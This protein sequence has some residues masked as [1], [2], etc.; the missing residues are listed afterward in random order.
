MLNPSCF[1][2]GR[3]SIAGS[4]WE[5]ESGL[6]SESAHPVMDLALVHPA[7]DLVWGLHS[8]SDSA[9]ESDFQSDSGSELAM[10]FDSALG[11]QSELEFQSESAFQSDSLP[12]YP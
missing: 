4:D 1:L 9:L 3:I 5:S 2:G 10:E 11:F 12:Q 6:D 8:A 7:M